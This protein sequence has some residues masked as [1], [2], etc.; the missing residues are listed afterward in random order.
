MEYE[1]RNAHLAERPVVVAMHYPPFSSSL[2]TLSKSAKYLRKKYVPLFEKYHVKM[3]LT[4]HTHIYERSIKSGVHYIIAGPAGG[5]RD[6]PTAF[7]GY[8]VV[9]FPFA[10]TFTK[11]KITQD[12]ITLNTLDQ[13]GEEIDRATIMY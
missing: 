13:A 1:L 10:R 5:S 11:I 7:N 4:G 9:S 3:V 6:I 12:R 2:F 8:K